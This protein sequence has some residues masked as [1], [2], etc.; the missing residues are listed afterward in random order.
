[1]ELFDSELLKSLAGPILGFAGVIFVA[2]FSSIVSIYI[3]KSSVKS[4]ISKHQIGSIIDRLVAARLSCYPH[5]YNILSEFAKFLRRQSSDIDGNFHINIHLKKYISAIDLWDSENSLLIGSNSIACIDRLRIFLNSIH[6][7]KNGII[8]NDDRD[9]IIFC[10]SRLELSL[11]HEV[12]IF[13]V[14]NRTDKIRIPNYGFI[15]EQ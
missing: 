14:E 11:K 5:L 15:D 1:M 7:E 4:E 13:L 6:L 12:G 3:S 8:S 2:F 9:F 10:L